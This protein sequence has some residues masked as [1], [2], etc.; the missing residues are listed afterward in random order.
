M[1]S[2]FIQPDIHAPPLTP[3]PPGGGGGAFLINAGG[4]RC[5]VPAHKVPRVQSEYCSSSYP[6]SFYGLKF[7]QFNVLR[8]RLGVRKDWLKQ[9]VGILIS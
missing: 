4:I 7:L 1:D 8:V 6:L 5:K 2:V 3:T 9:H